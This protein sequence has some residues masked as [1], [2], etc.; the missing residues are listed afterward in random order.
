MIFVIDIGNTNTVLGV[1]ANGKLYYQWRIKTDRYKTEDEFAM[2]FKSLFNDRGLSFS[3]VESIVISSVVPPIMDALEKMCT[4]YFDMKPLIVGADDVKLPLVINY[5]YPKEIGADRLVNAIGALHLYESPFIIIDFG[6][7]T[8]FCYVNEKQEYIGGI[9][10]PGIKISVDALYAR[11]S[12]LPKIEIEKPETVIGKSTVSAMQSGVYYGYIGQV[13]GI[14]HKIKEEIGQDA[15]V[16]AT[17]GLA[18]L[19]AEDSETID[20][21]C[22]HLTLIGLH[23]IYLHNKQLKDEVQ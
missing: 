13:D 2:I 23:Q 15:K 4:K 6:T 22:E 20:E 12:K 14:V 7:A 5:P 18:P 11:A 17:G 9:I 19:I 1:F 3:Q 8:T 21:V 10:A 16:I